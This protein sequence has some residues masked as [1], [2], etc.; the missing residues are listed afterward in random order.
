MPGARA[1]S[2][3]HAQPHLMDEAWA[4]E[5]FRPGPQRLQQRLS[6]AGVALVCTAASVDG[7]ERR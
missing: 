4:A 5:L 2:T 1:W 6:V 7:A 3:R